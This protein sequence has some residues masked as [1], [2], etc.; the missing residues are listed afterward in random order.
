MLKWDRVPLNLMTLETITDERDLLIRRMLL[1][2]GEATPWH[3]DRCRRFTVVVR[4]EHLQIEFEGSDESHRASVH[5]G[6][7]EWNE[8]TE[9]VHRAVNI[10]ASPYEEVVTFYRTVPN[11]E[12]QPA[13]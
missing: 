12:P 9:V 6:L 13:K 1:L 10:G 4:G 8:P 7:A 5:P 2:P 3:V 11:Q